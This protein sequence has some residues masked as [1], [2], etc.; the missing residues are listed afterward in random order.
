MYSRS[1]EEYLEEQEEARIEISFFSKPLT[2]K[3]DLFDFLYGLKKLWFIE[4]TPI[5]DKEVGDVERNIDLEFC[6]GDSGSI[7][8]VRSEFFR[9]KAEI[10]KK[11]GDSFF[12]VAQKNPT[13]IPPAQW[14]MQSLHP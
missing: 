12:R 13:R 1:R 10:G 6:E 8:K 14:L 4:H 3:Y 7:S 11:R 2:E 5:S 9:K